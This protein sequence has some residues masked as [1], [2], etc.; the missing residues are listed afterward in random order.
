VGGADSALC[1][2][3]G[4]IINGTGSS[5]ELNAVMSIKTELMLY[6]EVGRAIAQ[7]VGR[8]LPT[9]GS[10]VRTQVGSCGTCGG[11]SGSGASFLRALRFPL[12]ILIPLTA[13]QSSSSIIRGWYIRPING[14]RIRCTQSHP[15]PET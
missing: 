12:P 3:V 15:T 8:R 14:R 9:A 2:I 4:F 13:P 5:S 11:Q 10:R 6:T 1:L 7:A